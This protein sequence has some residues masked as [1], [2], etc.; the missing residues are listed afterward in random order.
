[1]AAASD[2]GRAWLARL[3]AW[4]R[5]RVSASWP[6]TAIRRAVRE[7]ARRRGQAIRR[8]RL[9]GM[10]R[11]RDGFTVDVRWTL[12]ETGRVRRE[13]VGLLSGLVDGAEPTPAEADALRRA[14][15]ENVALCD[16]ARVRLPKLRSCL[17]AKP[18]RAAE[19]AVDALERLTTQ[20]AESV[21]ARLTALE[22][23]EKRLLV[24]AAG[25]AS[26]IITPDAERVRAVDESLRRFETAADAALARAGALRVDPGVAT[27]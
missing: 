9:D 13:A 12:R 4:L 24:R 27:A 19:T 8:R 23:P 6:A 11:A 10:R 17:G 21:E 14:L 7:H 22:D 2:L 20:L 15:A 18:A 26:W 3:D 16:A 5:R 25:P 1:M